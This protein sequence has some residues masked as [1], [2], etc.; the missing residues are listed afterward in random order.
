MLRNKNHF[1]KR[2]EN[3]QKNKLATIKNNNNKQKQT[4]KE[5]QTNKALLALN[6]IQSINVGDLHH[7]DWVIIENFTI[8]FN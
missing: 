6:T 7:I 8:C 1:R 2:R 3:K 4:K 5:Q